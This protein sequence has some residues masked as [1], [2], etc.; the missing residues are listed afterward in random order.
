MECGLR[1]SGCEL[2]VRRRLQK[3]IN[4]AKFLTDNVIGV[5]AAFQ[6][7]WADLQFVDRGWKAAPT[8]K[9]L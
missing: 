7:R 1:V 8:S 9:K 6:P 5:G 3:L 4:A 2:R